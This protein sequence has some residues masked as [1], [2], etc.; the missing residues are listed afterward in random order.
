MS[1]V[2]SKHGGASTLASHEFTAEFFL[3]TNGTAQK[4][5]WTPSLGCCNVARIEI[6]WQKNAFQ[7]M[8]IFLTI[9]VSQLEA[10][11]GSISF[12]K[13]MEKN[14]QEAMFCDG[15]CERTFSCLFHLIEN[16]FQTFSIIH[17][18][19]FLLH[20]RIWQNGILQCQPLHLPAFL[21]SLPF[22]SEYCFVIFWFL[23][24]INW[25]LCCL[26]EKSKISN[27]MCA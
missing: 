21:A 1:F 6:E 4:L 13:E 5:M 24:V 8:E 14:F 11:E 10:I 9:R 18:L 19:F 26:L 23:K 17:I 20:S 15:A 25:N 27:K 16:Q 3:C 22:C 2:C 7:I 12:K